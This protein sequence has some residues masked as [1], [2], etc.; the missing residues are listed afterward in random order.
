MKKRKRK[1]E[2][3]NP[4]RL[5][6]VHMSHELSPKR[7]ILFWSLETGEKV[8][9]LINGIE[10][11]NQSPIFQ[12]FIDKSSRC[13]QLG[14]YGLHYVYGTNSPIIDI[15]VLSLSITNVVCIISSQLF[16][17]KEK[18]NTTAKNLIFKG[19]LK[20][21]LRLLNAIILFSRY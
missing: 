8:Q 11:I 10:A 21:F 16:G 2:K 3:A 13:Q 19:I 6:C 15:N 18:L 17:E 14:K 9:N 12:I 4:K 1:K 5:V 7:H 20:S